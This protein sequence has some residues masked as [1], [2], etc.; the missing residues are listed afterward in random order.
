MIWFDLDNSPH[1]PLFRPV[2]EYL[3][4]KKI[5]FKITARDFAQ[6]L[7]LLKLWN[8]RH[9][10]IGT[11]GGRNKIK[12][13]LNTYNRSTQ[14]KKFAK[15]FHFS[16]AVSHG[17]RS[18]LVAARRLKIKSLLMMDYEYTE[19]KIFNYFSGNLLIPHLIPDERLASCGINL[20]KVIR[21]NGFKEELYL[22]AFKPDSGFRKSIDVS[23]DSILVVI[24]PP[25]M[26]GN[27]H[28]EKSEKLLVKAIE[29]F[30][31]SPNVT[32]LI[33]ARARQDRKYILSKCT[34]SDNVKFLENAV[35]G[36]QLVYAADIVLSGGGTMNRE[37]ALLGTRTYSIFTGRKPYLDEYLASQGRMKFIESEKDIEDI[38][39][40][41]TAK[42]PSFVTHKNLAAEIS[43]IIIGLAK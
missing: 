39:I 35:D 33:I 10:P 18:Q 4:S 15:D 11:H 42:P 28:D 8:I 40:E 9:V 38:A 30:S 6:T 24:R 36:S 19:T 41:R 27:Y 25:G 1:V 13:V 7:D 34:M 31:A 29:H 23:D 14:L 22:A 37:S 17:S 26:T 32:C 12:K 21:Y 20:K 3:D 43:E 5:D 2:F 16:L